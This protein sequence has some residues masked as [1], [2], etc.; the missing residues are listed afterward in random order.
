MDKYGNSNASGSGDAEQGERWT[1]R[2]RG[3]I[4]Q[5]EA[6]PRRPHQPTGNYKTFQYVAFHSHMFIYII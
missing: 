3:R 2:G 5:D 1:G 6:P 4:N